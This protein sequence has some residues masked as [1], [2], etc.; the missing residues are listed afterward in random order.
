MARRYPP[1]RGWPASLSTH[2]IAFAL[3][4]AAS[5]CAVA[6]PP[7]ASSNIGSASPSQ[8]TEKTR[9]PLGI[10]DV[11]KR[12][13][14]WYPV[15]IVDKAPALRNVRPEIA[16]DGWRPFIE[17]MQA[18]LSAGDR[19]LHR[20]MLHTPF[21]REQPVQFDA[22]LEA[23]QNRDL[24]KVTDGFVD[25]WRAVTPASS[26]GGLDV[27]AYIGSP[28]LDPDSSR[29]LE[30]QGKEAFFRRARQAVEPIIAAGMA[31]GL[32]AAVPA[33][34][35]SVTYELA[36]WLRDRGTEVYV[37]ANPPADYSWWFD[38]P[39]IVIE[40]TW[41]K[42]KN[43]PRFASR[44][45]L[46]RELVRLVRVRPNWV[47]SNPPSA[48]PEA[49]CR[50]IADGDTLAISGLVLLQPERTL[51]SLVDCANARRR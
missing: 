38:Y 26:D 28:R 30:V 12:V 24:R 40:E 51:Q 1:R 22:Y 27:I 32:D 5:G 35:D 25:A 16:R 48:W 11:R 31:V 3:L 43:D 17:A 15:G 49:A 2:L 44:Q 45:Q 14:A 42:R 41:Q 7:A 46:E 50:V 20:V 19:N 10:Q 33:S 47:R 4:G 18:Q 8:T 34:A 21:G 39:V 29:V 9:E 13:I 36:E 37:E 6:T 23:R